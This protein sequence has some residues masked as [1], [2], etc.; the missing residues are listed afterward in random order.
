[1]RIINLGQV[2][3]IEERLLEQLHFLK[4]TECELERVLG[5]VLD[6]CRDE[7]TLQN[8]YKAIEEIKEEMHTLKQMVYCLQGVRYT[9]SETEKR[10]VDTYDLERIMY[11]RPT[12]G[13][14][15]ITG[16]DGLEG[17][18]PF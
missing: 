11:P 5:I 17:L 7:Q 18:L 3:A 9:Y 13:R 16:L 15:V 12:F 10:I 1:M 4:K 8:L 6:L 14:S 2:Q